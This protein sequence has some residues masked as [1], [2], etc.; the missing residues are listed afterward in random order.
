MCLVIAPNYRVGKL[1]QLQL[2]NHPQITQQ[3]KIWRIFCWVSS[4]GFS[5][6]V[7]QDVGRVL[8]ARCERS[9][10]RR[11]WEKGGSTGGSLKERLEGKGFCKGWKW[12]KEFGEETD[13]F[14]INKV[15]ILAMA[16]WGWLSHF[17]GGQKFCIPQFHLWWKS[18]QTIS[19][20][21]W[22]NILCDA[23]AS[24]KYKPGSMAGVLF[25][26]CLF[27]FLFHKSG[28]N[29]QTVNYCLWCTFLSLKKPKQP[30]TVAPLKNCNGSGFSA[31]F[32]HCV[33]EVWANTP[34]TAE[35][36][37]GSHSTATVHSHWKIEEPCLWRQ[38]GK[39]T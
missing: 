6:K 2:L 15:I 5:L 3:P 21:I 7:Q 8:G 12:W 9:G 39:C 13:G 26:C 35:Y 22:I 33:L 31:V 20:N 11:R 4:L 37:I 28:L 24:G 27:Q 29:I 18:M 23:R 17:K 34:L 1:S 25:T 36:G 38:M 14:I 10:E 32:E 19:S 16:A 30:S